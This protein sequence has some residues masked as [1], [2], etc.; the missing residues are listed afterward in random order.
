MDNPH[1]SPDLAAAVR[2]LALAAQPLSDA[3]LSQPY[4]WGAHQ[5]GARFALLGAMH[6]LRALAVRLAAERRRAGQPLTR[7]Q[8]ALGQYHAACRDLEAVMLG[9]S[10]EE[11]DAS[12]APGEWPL[13]Y[14]YSHMVGAERNFFALV[15][16][17]LRRQRDGGDLSTTLPDGEA[18]RLFGPFE[19]TFGPLM[20]SGIQAGVAEFHAG[21]HDRALAEF[22]GISDDEIEGL[23]VWWEQ[24]PYTLEYRLHRFDAHLRQHTAQAEKTLDQLGR[25]ANE[26]R[27]LIRLVYAA[28]AEVEA[29]LIGA[30][31]LAPEARA[32]LAAALLGR[33]AELPAV[34]GRAR[35]LIAAVQAG[36]RARV[37]AL[38]AEDAALANATDAS[39]V[40]AA[41]VA[42]YYGEPAIADLLADTAG[43]ELEI[44]DGVALGRMAV[45]EAM[46]ADWG[47]FILNEFSRD[48]YTPLQ[49]A[50]FF[51]REDIARWLVGKG[52]SLTAVSRNRMAIQ[53]LHAAAAGNHLGIVRLLLD[54][55]ADPNAVQ[56]DSFRPLHSA[57][58]NGNAAMVALL[59]ERG[60]DPA[61]P[62]DRGRTARALAEVGGHGDVVALL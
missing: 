12:P 36:D 33:A 15:H 57:A 4:R 17:G 9:V 58:Q 3:D 37:E 55:G 60:A 35:E 26:A 21:I 30:P 25:P 38:L 54:A 48:G 22:A 44:W 53:P 7:A 20:E 27:R 2:Q 52:A 8:H 62:D 39:G 23:S 11:Y 41:R 16:Y 61:L 28:L 6:E 56:S 1:A 18:N 51:G 5:E 14:V 42:A 43:V 45:V 46:V 47:D 32:D 59:L 31:D 19:T 34:V 13:R 49:L 40:P 24:E 10:A 29:A 50:C